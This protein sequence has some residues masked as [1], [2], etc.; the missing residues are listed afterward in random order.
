MDKFTHVKTYHEFYDEI[1]HLGGIPILGQSL[2]YP[3]KEPSS[4]CEEV[5]VTSLE[6]KFHLDDVI[7]R[8]ENRRLDENSTPFQSV[9]QPGPSQ[10]VPPKWLTK[11]LESVHPDEVGKTRTIISSRQDGGSVDN[12]KL[13][14]VDEMVVSYDSEL[15]LSTNLEPSSFE[16]VTS[17]DEWKESMQKEYYARIKNGKWN[18]VD[19]PFGTKP[20]GCNW[21][22][23]NK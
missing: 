2:E 10:K 20:I 15:S 1:P 4:P 22:F 23:K 13:G 17:H 11:T 12:P 3:F 6:P 14:D 9:K 21:V 16:E 7:E 5:L 18:L 8:I 19:L